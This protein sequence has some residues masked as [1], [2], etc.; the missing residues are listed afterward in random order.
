MEIGYQNINNNIK[1]M[2]YF[3]VMNTVTTKVI[4]QA[5]CKIFWRLNL[6]ATKMVQF[7]AFSNYFITIRK[8]HTSMKNIYKYKIHL[9]YKQLK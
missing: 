9:L 4:Q 8:V 2:K 3:K 5:N 7:Y 1:I 6:I